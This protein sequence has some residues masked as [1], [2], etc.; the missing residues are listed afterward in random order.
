MP[1][2]VPRSCG[3]LWQVQLSQKIGRPKGTV[4]QRQVEGTMA[5]ASRAVSSLAFE[6]DQLPCF[7]WTSP[8]PVFMAMLCAHVLDIPAANT[9]YQLGL[10]EQVVP[11]MVVCFSNTA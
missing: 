11:A 9:I 2:E 5:H 8:G 3:S 7:S 1:S 6:K 10:L 4:E